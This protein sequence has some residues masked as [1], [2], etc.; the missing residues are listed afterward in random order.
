MP[1]FADVS[2]T[3]VGIWQTID[4]HTH[5]PTALVQITQNGDGTFSGKI[6]KD[7]V[8][9]FRTPIIIRIPSCPILPVAVHLLRGRPN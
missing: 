5:Q 4:D 6:I 8:C 3:P 7:S 9:H 1:A 2:G